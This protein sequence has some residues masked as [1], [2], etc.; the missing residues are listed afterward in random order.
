MRPAS[1]SGV[2]LIAL[3]AVPAVARAQTLAQR[4]DRV[5]D[6][7]VRLSY[8]ARPGVCGNGRN[9]S[10]HDGGRRDEWQSDC[11]EGPVR[12]VVERRE[13]RITDLRAYVGGHWRGSADADLGQV[14]AR[15][16]GQWL[17]AVAEAGG[18]AAEEAVFPATLADSMEAWPGLLRIARSAKAENKT[19]KSAIFWLGQAAADAATRGLDSI[20]VDDDEDREVRESAIFALSQRP[21]E[22]GIPVLIRIARSS[23][24][25][26]L[27]RTALFWL[28]QSEDPAALRL[29]EE[30]LSGS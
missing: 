10:T 16:A 30:L 5:K 19:R 7:T 23:K 4:I 22:E 6:G 8:A 9:I 11:E 17:L 25:P 2:S 28:G 20:A 1:L 15:E 14:P 27:R 18:R 21:H 26:K 29:F 13:G 3:L 12:L 24:D